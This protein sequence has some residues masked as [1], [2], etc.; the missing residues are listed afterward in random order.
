MRKPSHLRMQVGGRLLF[1]VELRGLEPLT[2]W[3]PAN[4]S[5]N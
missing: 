4:R 1:L 3:L 5:P 2:Y